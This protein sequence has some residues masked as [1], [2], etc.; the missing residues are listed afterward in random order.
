MLPRVVGQLPA[1]PD[2]ELLEGVRQVC[3]HGSRRNS[4]HHLYVL[5]SGSQELGRHL[6]FRDH[7]KQ[8]PQARDDFA[9]IKIDLA[10]SA[11]AAGYSQAK[12]A[13]IQSTMA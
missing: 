1:G 7:L 3:T 10:P 12:A 11:D 6:A 9:K 2:L 13:F 5:I 4:Q 8:E